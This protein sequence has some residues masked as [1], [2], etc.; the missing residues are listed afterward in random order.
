MTELWLRPSNSEVVSLYHKHPGLQHAGDA[1]IDLFIPRNNVVPANAR[2]FVIDHEISCC[3]ISQGAQ[4]SYYLYPR[5]SLAKTPLRVA[6][7]VGI[8][9]SG[10]RGSVMALVDNMSDQPFSLVEGTRLFQI[11]SPFLSGLRLKLVDSLPDS[12]RGTGGIGSTG[13]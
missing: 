4:C 9:D 5:S 13:K 8:I 12:T 11:C 7:S 10:Y 3:M 1:G 2:G 6:N